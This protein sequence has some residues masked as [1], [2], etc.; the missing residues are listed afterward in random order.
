MEQ[1]MSRA[2][3]DDREDAV[4]AAAKHVLSRWREWWGHRS[5]LDAMHPDDIARLAHDLGVTGPELRDLA[6]R[7]P[8]AGHLL[9]ER[10][11][12]LGL[13]RAD[14][15]RT[16]PGLM[17]D[18]ERTCSCCNEKGVCERDLAAHPDSPAWGGYCPNAENLTAAKID[19]DR[20]LP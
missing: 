16:A 3:D 14:V 10:M 4:L 12:V 5:D 17:R 2:K 15:E 7:G 13:T 6:A 19:K 11:R 9:H 8:E 18:L 1:A 20:A